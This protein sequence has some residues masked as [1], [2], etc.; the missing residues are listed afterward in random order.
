MSTKTIRFTENQ[1]QN[2]YR[3]I[4]ANQHRNKE[5]PEIVN[6]LKEAS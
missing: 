1:F 6:V 2:L 4:N 5:L 3:F